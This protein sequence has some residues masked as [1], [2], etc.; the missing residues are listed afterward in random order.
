[1]ETT[2]VADL[3]AHL[4]ATL[5]RVKA[6]EEVL[7]TEHG[8]PI[9]RLVPVGPTLVGSVERLVRTGLVRPPIAPL[10]EQFWRRPQPAD[11]EGAVLAALLAE[12][13]E[14]R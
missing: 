8:R 14:G 2:G 4:S 9:A 7:I 12:R 3:K 5:A 6:G 10:E 13:D 11:P 1:M